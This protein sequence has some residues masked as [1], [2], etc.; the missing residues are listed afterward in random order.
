MGDTVFIDIEPGI[1]SSYP[2]TYNEYNRRLTVGL[3]T[4]VQAGVNSTSNTISITNHKLTTGDPVI[5]E[6]TSAVSGLTDQSIYY[7]IRG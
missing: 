1:T 3:S 5:Y 6:S 7:V 2:L 4:F